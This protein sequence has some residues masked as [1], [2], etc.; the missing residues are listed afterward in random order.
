MVIQSALK[1]FQIIINHNICIRNKSN[2]NSKEVSRCC[3]CKT[4]AG[5]DPLSHI[6]DRLDTGSIQIVIVLS[7][8]DELVLLDVFL[9]LLSWVHKVII[10][11]VHFIIPPWPGSIWNWLKKDPG[12]S[13]IRLG[14]SVLKHIKIIIIIIIYI[15][16]HEKYLKLSENGG[17]IYVQLQINYYMSI[18]RGD[19]L[20]DRIAA[21]I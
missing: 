15:L 6:F 9:H 5:T 11:P 13:F 8:L 17:Q 18:F 14:Y 4:T 21:V 20:K 3:G 1:A 19:I 12:F 7:S 2:N 16:I 10:S